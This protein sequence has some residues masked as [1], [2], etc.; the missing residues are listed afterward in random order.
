AVPGG[1]DE[2]SLID[3]IAAIDAA[4]KG[5]AEYVQ[6]TGHDRDEIADRIEHRHGHRKQ[7]LPCDHADEWAGDRGPAAVDD[8]TQMLERGNVG[9]DTPLMAGIVGEDDE[10]RADD[11]QRLEQRQRAEVVMQIVLEPFR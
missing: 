7:R 1:K 4:E 10:L 9:A 8:T 3:R 6:G 2:L 5:R 11:D